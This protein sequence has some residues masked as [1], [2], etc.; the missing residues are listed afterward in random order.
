MTTRPSIAAVD[1]PIELWHETNRERW[2]QGRIVVEPVSLWWATRGRKG[3]TVEAGRPCP[4]E[5]IAVM[6]GHE[7][8][9]MRDM[10]VST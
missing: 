8:R 2:D 10:E 4:V 5:A 1:G 6:L 3:G 9:G 7:A